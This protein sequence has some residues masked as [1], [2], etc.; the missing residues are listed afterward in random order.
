MLRRSASGETRLC[1]CHVVRRSF[2]FNTRLVALAAEPKSARGIAL[3]A[4]LHLAAL[5]LLIWSEREVASA[6]AFLLSWG[7]LNC[8]WLV[9]LRRPAEPRPRCRWR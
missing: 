4:A 2:S 8:L 5:G 7:L 9:L 6:V 3:L 1:Q